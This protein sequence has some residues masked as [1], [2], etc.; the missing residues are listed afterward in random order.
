MPISTEYSAG[1]V[2]TSLV[3]YIRERDV[4]F[5]ARNL[6]PYKLATLFFDDVA[7]NGYCQVGS[8]IKVDA[9]KVI[10]ISSNNTGTIT[11]ND[12]VYQG[13]SNTSN[14]FGAV[15]DAWYTSNST[16]V[17]KTLTG[18]FDETTQLYIEGVSGA[19]TGITY[20]N[21]NVGSVTT[22]HTSDIFDINEGVIDP[23]AGNAFARVIATS[24]ENIMYIDHNYININVEAVGVN[25]ISSMSSDYKVGDIV[26]QTRDGTP[27]FD[28][29]KIVF[30][31]YVEYYNAIGTPTIAIAPINGSVVANSTSAGSN[32]NVRFWNASNT[33]AKPLAAS[34]FNKY[35]FSSYAGHN[36]QSATDSTKSIKV[37]SYRH[38][39]GVFANTNVPNNQSVILNTTSGTEAGVNGN[40]IYFTTGTGVG[41]IRRV[42]AI[43]GDIAVLNSSISFAVTSN[44]HYSVGNFIVDDHGTIAGIFHIPSS[45]TVKFKTGDRIFTVTDTNTYDDPNYGMRATHRYSASGVL[46]TKQRIQMT[47]L[48]TP[49]PETE[50]DSLV[51]PINP[52]DRTF[53]TDTYKSPVTGSSGSSI[54]R[55]PLG[56]GLS[57]TFF[58]PKKASNSQDYGMF[59]SSIDLFFKT[60]P[61][62]AAGNMQL[63][64][65]VRIAEVVNGYPTKN[66]LASKTVQAKDVKI[67]SLPSISNTSTITKFAFNDPVYLQ[68]NHEYA[69]VIGSD[70]P[71]YSVYTA[72]LGETVLGSDPP[73]RISEQPYAGSFFRSQNSSTWTPYQNEDLMF[74]INKAVFASSGTATFNLEKAPIGVSFIDKTLL[75]SS[76][77]A[78][79]AANLSY[80]ISGIYANTYSYDGG[81]SIV[82]YKPLEYGSLFDKTNKNLTSALNRRSLRAGNA[83]SFIVTVD[84]STADP[85][86]SPILNTERFALQAFSYDIN[87]ANLAN[88]FISLTYTGAG[89]NATAT[90]GNSVFGS[91]N[92]TVNN[93][94]QLYREQF[95]ANN[96]N[97]GFY[98]ITITNNPNDSGSGAQ[99]FAVANTD[100]SNTVN[101][102][103]LTNPGSGYLETPTISITT[104]NATSNI[105]A[106]A[107]VAGETDKSGGNIVSKYISR[108]IILEDGFDS[109]DISVFMDAIRV[110]GTDIQVYYKVVSSEDPDL[111][112]DKSWRR[113]Q[114]VKDTFSKDY[115]TKIT[116]QFKPDLNVNQISYT[117]NGVNYPIG[118]T[119]KSFAIKVCL[120]TTDGAIVPKLDNLRISA[121]PAG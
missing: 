13:T 102:I 55:V 35:H 74:V 32:A 6:K 107:L 31:G 89:Y 37:T 62:V 65:T 53:N 11:A 45:S 34:S 49:L 78:F 83:N 67:S 56:D 61:S 105:Q 94:A 120:L 91:S 85:D 41:T 16:I 7:V 43:D 66:Y 2:D 118:G 113:M 63:P 68:P 54:P 80:E 96:W 70:S 58:T 59:V 88:S 48:I 52:A 46:N 22:Y 84:M 42:V 10:V 5:V 23:G 39:S 15:V 36:V 33:S 76:D 4:D 8:K 17:L 14:T 109:S 72:V 27:G 110:T 103:V 106:T 60:K 108:E 19:N 29:T 9:K 50:A 44:T 38:F 93:Y 3:P 99:G 75:V 92:S 77:L 64:V 24:G 47:P 111:L 101:Y 86:I 28:D 100:G 26:Y 90:S 51:S 97:V 121:L 69:I 71:D 114:K 104:G 87:N 57:Q 81:N 40:L 20:A 115:N 119:F 98:N 12:I 112:S 30:K 25:V 73:R 95:L 116:L 117:E 79:P 18:D 1:T 82:P 21:C